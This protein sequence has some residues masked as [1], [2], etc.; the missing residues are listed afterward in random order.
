MVNLP[1]VGQ[2]MAKSHLPLANWAMLNPAVQEMLPLSY[3]ISRKER[4]PARKGTEIRSS[5]LM[6]SWK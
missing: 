6:L 1:G 3:Q 5:S 2:A 4:N